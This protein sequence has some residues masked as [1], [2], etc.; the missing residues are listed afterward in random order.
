MGRGDKKSKK[1]KVSKGSFGVSRNRKTIKARLKRSTTKK[2]A[3][4][5]SAAKPKR[6]AAK[7]G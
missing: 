2:S 6:T 3:D 1:G 5:E 4:E 7:K